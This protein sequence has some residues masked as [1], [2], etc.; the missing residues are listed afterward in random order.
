MRTLLIIS[1]LFVAL[2]AGAANAAPRTTPYESY[3]EQMGLK[4]LTCPK[5]MSSPEAASIWKGL[6]TAK[7]NSDEYRALVARYLRLSDA[8]RTEWLEWVDVAP[9]AIVT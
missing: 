6:A 7:P 2:C 5:A 4:R 1:A 9:R 8:C 3:V